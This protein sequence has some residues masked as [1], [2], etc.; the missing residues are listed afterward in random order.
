MLLRRGFQI[1]S[2]GS[3]LHVRNVGVITQPGDSAT[4][5]QIAAERLGNFGPNPSQ[6]GER[7]HWQRQPLTKGDLPTMITPVGDILYWQKIPLWKD[8]NEEEFL[9]Y[10]WQVCQQTHNN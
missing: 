6:I 3:I 1:P 4:S 2:N 8:V 10:Q 7:L 5:T 9:S